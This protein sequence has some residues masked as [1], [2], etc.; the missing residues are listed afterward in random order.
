MCKVWKESVRRVLYVLGINYVE[1]YFILL[2]FNRLIFFECLLGI[3]N[4]NMMLC[5]KLGIL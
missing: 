3:G 1:V 5:L 2:F 4:V